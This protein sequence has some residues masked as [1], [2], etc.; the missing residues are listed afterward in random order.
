MCSMKLIIDRNPDPTDF[1]VYLHPSKMKE[2]DISNG[3]AL[4]IISVQKRDGKYDTYNIAAIA[5]SSKNKSN[6]FSIQMNR[7][8]RYNLHSY[9]GEF[10]EVDKYDRVMEAISVEIAAF[11]DSVIGISGDLNKVI[12][13]SSVD[14][15]NI[16]WF[17]GFVLPVFGLN[18][19]IEFKVVN[20]IPNVPVLVKKRQQIRIL[21]GNLERNEKINPIYDV[22]SYDSIGGLDSEIN[23]I[24]SYIE[25]PLQHSQ[26]YMN[27]FGIS[28]TR[29]V[30][31]SGKSGCGKTLL[32][33]AIEN[34][35]PLSFIR[36]PGIDLLSLDT[37]KAISVLKAL[38]SKA[39]YTSPSIIFIDDIN[40]IILDE[41]NSKGHSKLYYE[42][43][44]LLEN[45]QSKNN[46]VV[47]GTTD[48]TSEIPDDFK[49]AKRFS[50]IIEIPE[51]ESN[52][53]VQIFSTLTRSVRVSKKI[54]RY[55]FESNKIN[56]AA[57][58]A[59]LYH[60]NL[61]DNINDIIKDDNDESISVDELLLIK[62][63]KN[64]TIDMNEEEEEDEDIE[65]KNVSCNSRRKKI[66]LGAPLSPS[67][68]YHSDN[69]L[70]Q[71]FNKSIEKLKL[72]TNQNN[73]QFTL[74]ENQISNSL[75]N[76][77]DSFNIDPINNLSFHTH[78]ISTPKLET[79]GKRKRHHHKHKH[80]HSHKHQN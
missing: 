45:I 29:T 52:K 50:T 64:M 15:N 51:L 4:R 63:G 30:L 1:R 78:V 2:L 38:F 72:S 71:K 57:E 70:S 79:E 37:D 34:E 31:L 49:T 22:V 19:I 20:A 77:S 33:K 55:V 42:L 6:V 14:F 54:I 26:V 39:I 76:E 48:D 7:A 10:V 35:V 62:I 27:Y 8:L 5:Y 59:K 24:R 47:I 13:N 36:I 74:P 21:S 58:L 65:L 66:V 43:L 53:K 44:L 80:K 17:N 32:G 46:I 60:E 61:I 16:L 41:P 69:L 40:L 67:Y 56:N 11:E 18:R 73:E 12:D 9:L 3:S 68:V 75:N 28:P 25:F 23:E